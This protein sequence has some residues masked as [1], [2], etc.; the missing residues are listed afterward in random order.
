MR[1]VPERLQDILDAID[2]VNR[3]TQQGKTAFEG[4]ELIQV[5]VVH[6][7]EIIGEAVK[8]L[9]D[10]LLNKYPEIPWGQI[11]GLRNRLIHE[12]FRVDPEVIWNIARQDLP[13][14]KTVVSRM[15]EESLQ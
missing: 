15:L 4:Q 1:R 7:C 3:Y 9:P 5:W 13:P 6:H 10:E 2:A 8:S 14:L 12:Y 11:I